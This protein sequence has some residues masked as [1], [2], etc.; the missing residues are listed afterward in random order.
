M[1][2]AFALLLFLTPCFVFA[3]YLGTREEK[4]SAPMTSAGG[5]IGVG[6]LVQM[7]IALA[8]VL[9]LVKWVLPKFLGKLNQRLVP[10]LGSTI[11]VEESAAFAGGNLY[12]VNARGKTLLLSAT[13]TGVTMLADLTDAPAEP[14]VETFQE[15]LEEADP[16]KGAPAQ[17]IVV[18]EEDPAQQA[19][20]R[21]QRLLTEPS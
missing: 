10:S 1:R 14:Q 12:I 2:K 3:G 8:I 13:N 21:L 7:A 5:P 4:T 6:S 20:E 11:K 9:A 15:I 19:L 16:E 18:H 17:A